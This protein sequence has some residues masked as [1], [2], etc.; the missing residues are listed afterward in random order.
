M[1]KTWQDRLVKESDK[2][3]K[4]LDK[5]TEFIGGDKDSPFCKLNE[6]KRDLLVAQHSAMHTYHNILDIRMK[7]EGLK[8][9]VDDVN[10]N[11]APIE[12]FQEPI[13]LGP[14]KSTEEMMEAMKNQLKKDND[15]RNSK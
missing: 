11:K 8:E 2:L 6:A 1:K 10:A 13:I 9:C 4:K 12:E 3:G 14:F 15:A 7:R 5:L